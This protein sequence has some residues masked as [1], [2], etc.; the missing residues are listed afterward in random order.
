MAHG[1]EQL[2]IAEM[3]VGAVIGFL[4]GGY[5]AGTDRNRLVVLLV[6]LMAGLF[7]TALLLLGKFGVEPDGA[8]SAGVLAYLQFTLVLAGVY[9]ALPL[10]I[11][12]VLALAV[13]SRHPPHKRNEKSR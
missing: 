9:L 11:A 13:L 2:V 4:A 3:L 7:V 10:V 1:S 6:A 8:L 5:A 12:Y